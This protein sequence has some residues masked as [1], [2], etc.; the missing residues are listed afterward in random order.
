MC[1]LTVDVHAKSGSLSRV[2][3][4]LKMEKMKL[5]G[6]FKV[7]LV[8]LPWSELLDDTLSKYLSKYWKSNVSRERFP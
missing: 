6:S 3:L 8:T 5:N 2:M 1:H 4:K 7:S